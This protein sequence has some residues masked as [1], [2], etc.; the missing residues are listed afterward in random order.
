ME[1]QKPEKPEM[2]HT[3]TSAPVESPPAEEVRPDIAR[4]AG[5]EQEQETLPNLGED[6]GI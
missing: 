6:P 2:P 5:P 4:E 1:S 3:Q